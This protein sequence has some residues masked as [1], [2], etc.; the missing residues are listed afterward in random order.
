MTPPLTLTEQEQKA[1]AKRC[2]WVGMVL[3]TTDPARIIGFCVPDKGTS[4]EHATEATVLPT[5]SQA[6]RAVVAVDS[7]HN[8][9]FALVNQKDGLC[10][11]F[12]V[13]LKQVY[14]FPEFRD[15][16]ETAEAK[17]E[18]KFSDKIKEWKNGVMA[19]QHAE[20][21]ANHRVQE[22]RGKIGSSTLSLPMRASTRNQVQAL[23][24]TYE[25]TNASWA[26]DALSQ[27]LS[28]YDADLK[29]APSWRFTG[30][31]TLVSIGKEFT[32]DDAIQAVKDISVRKQSRL[33]IDRIRY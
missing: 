21:K 26:L 16:K 23:G 17:R 20:V 13:D 3:L 19:K 10:E 8:Q 18:I 22:S 1:S 28:Q 4:I 5:E 25:L 24:A 9:Y 31:H 15:D 14:F 7:K 6:L 27:V 32:E 29:S 2:V 11:G 12:K 30:L 33:L